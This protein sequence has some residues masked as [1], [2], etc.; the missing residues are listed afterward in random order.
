MAILV[1]DRHP[2][3][4]DLLAARL[5]EA[6]PGVR[7][8]SAA[9]VDEALTVAND[10]PDI[11]LALFDADLPGMGDLQGLGRFLSVHPR[12]RTGVL[13]DR[14]D[15]ASCRKAMRLGAAGCL[16]KCEP[17][18]ALLSF[19][20]RVSTDTACLPAP[21]VRIQATPDDLRLTGREAEVLDGLWRGKSNREI[22]DELGVREVTVKMHLRRLYR[23]LDCR[24]RTEAVRV[25]LER[26]LLAQSA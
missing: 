22:A 13:S 19:V 15:R 8:V 26:G 4:N 21:V 24:N 5:R 9:S 17:V 20:Q 11:D 14:V 6:W 18:E 16:G 7:V 23:T 3:I 2:L 12:V 10:H 25:G 1:A